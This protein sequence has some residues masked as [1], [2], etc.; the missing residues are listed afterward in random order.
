MDSLLRKIE[1]L[2]YKFI[3]TPEIPHS[4]LVKYSY[5]FCS[6]VVGASNLSDIEQDML[7]QQINN[8]KFQEGETYEENE[9]LL[10]IFEY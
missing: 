8:L 6:T 5:Q 2:N 9:R 7:L 3:K 1:I 4:S 10:T